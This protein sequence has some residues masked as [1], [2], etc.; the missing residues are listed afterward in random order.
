METDPF[1]LSRR[2]RLVAQRPYLCFM[3]LA[4]FAYVLV[5]AETMPVGRGATGLG[6]GAI[7]AGGG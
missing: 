5:L 1:A 7:G 4:K 6:I 3:S 2:W